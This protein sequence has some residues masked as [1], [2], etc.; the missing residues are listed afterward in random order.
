LNNKNINECDPPTPTHDSQ[1]E[2]Y[3]AQVRRNL[4]DYIRENYFQIL[5]RVVELIEFSPDAHVLDIGA[6]TGLLAERVTHSNIKLYGIDISEKM[7]DQIR[8]KGLR[9]ELR[10]GH[11]LDIPF[12]DKQ[13]ECVVSTFAFHHVPDR[14]KVTAFDEMRRVMKP[15]GRLIIADF[16]TENDNQRKKLIHRFHKEGRQDMILELNDEEFMNIEHAIGYFESH[17]YKVSVER[18]ST[19]TWIF[20]AS[21]F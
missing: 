12:D 19:L 15:N 1:A 21:S 4:G 6:G 16:M 9:I 2:N 20:S 18:G 13:F 5:D 17:G 7:M 11:F 8:K 14:L 10:T 3:D